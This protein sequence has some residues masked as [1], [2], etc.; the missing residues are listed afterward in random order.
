MH[1]QAVIEEL[2]GLPLM[3]CKLGN[4]TMSPD[5]KPRGKPLF[6]HGVVV[7]PAVLLSCLGKLL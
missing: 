4:G 1:C 5:T 2:W 3:G 7:P 6:P